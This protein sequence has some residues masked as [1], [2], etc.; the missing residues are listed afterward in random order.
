MATGKSNKTIFRTGVLVSMMAFY[1]SCGKD[2]FPPDSPPGDLGSEVSTET[3]SFFRWGLGEK[4]SPL[5]EDLKLVFLAGVWAQSH[6][7]GK[8]QRDK[9]TKG[10]EKTAFSALC[11]CHS[12]PL[13]LKLSASADSG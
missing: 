12:V 1:F 5:D 6:K 7:E 3:S 10:K 9:D 2:V 13:S 8:A 11:L 4:P